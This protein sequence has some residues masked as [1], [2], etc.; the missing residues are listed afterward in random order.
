MTSY[1]KNY[2]ITKLLPLL[3][4]AFG[5]KGA[6]SQ[7]VPSPSAEQSQYSMETDVVPIQHPVDVPESVVQLLRT[8]RLISNCARAAKM[9]PDQVP[10]LWFVA[11]EI[12]LDGP[13]ERDLLV[14]GR[15]LHASP[16]PNACLMGANIK[17]F[18]VFRKTQNDY[19]LVLSIGAHDLR[20]L[21]TRS[22]G[23]RDIEVSAMTAVT[24]YSATYRFDGD[25]YQASKTD[26]SLRGR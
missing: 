14:Q 10:A 21:R 24:G 3:I 19:S 25:K 17:P 8:D 16:S 23:F 7:D 13:H 18:W 2:R 15:D 1:S 4:L 5:V 12:H 6:G 9:S 26:S 11:S 22:K 20:V